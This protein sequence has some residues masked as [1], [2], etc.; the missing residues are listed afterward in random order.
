MGNWPSTEL[1]SEIVLGI[2]LGLVLENC[3]KK[4]KELYLNLL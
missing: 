1:K 2:V 3:T 4:I